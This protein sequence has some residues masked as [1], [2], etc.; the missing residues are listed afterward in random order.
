[1]KKNL[2]IIIK[3]NEKELKNKEKIILTYKPIYEEVRKT[4][5]DLYI[6]GSICEKLESLGLIEIDE[7][8]KAYFTNFKMYESKN[9]IEIT[10]DQFILSNNYFEELYE[11]VIKNKNILK[12][13][14]NSEKKI[15]NQYINNSILKWRIN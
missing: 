12:I 8:E 4:I 11:I 3:L 7:K 14:F 13:E 2:E 10:K 6:L 15:N 5:S 9:E 1:M